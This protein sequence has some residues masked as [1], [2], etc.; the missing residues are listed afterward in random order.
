MSRLD[1]GTVASLCSTLSLLWGSSSLLG[2]VPLDGITTLARHLT[3]KLGEEHELSQMLWSAIRAE[4]GRRGP[5]GSEVLRRWAELGRVL[6][7][8]ARRL[9]VELGRAA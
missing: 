1:Q 5:A 7:A 6:G 8:E 3:N 2:D 4:R 9:E